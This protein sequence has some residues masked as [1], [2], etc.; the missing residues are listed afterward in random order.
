MDAADVCTRFNLPE[1]NINPKLAVRVEQI[2]SLGGFPDGC[3]KEV[4]VLL[5]KLASSARSL[6]AS[7][8]GAIARLVGEQA[9]V[10]NNQLEAAIKFLATQDAVDEE[11]LRAESGVGVNVSDE[12]LRAA[13]AAVVEAEKA[14]IA[15]MRYRTNTG[16]LVRKV[17][18]GPGADRLRWA[19][20]GSLKRAVDEAIAAHLGPKTEADLAETPVKKAPKDKGKGKPEPVNGK[21]VADN[22]VSEVVGAARKFPKPEENVGEP[23]FA[24]NDP[25]VL[26][27][28][29]HAT[30][31]KVITRFPPEPN[32]GGVGAVPPPPSPYGRVSLLTNP[33]GRGPR[34]LSAHRPRQSDANE[35][36]LREGHRRRDRVALRRHQPR[37]GGRALL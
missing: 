9:I 22:A 15:E 19:D 31:G 8:A 35:L 7:H 24:L 34:R 10:R 14:S 12:E 23:P 27:R 36:R 1:S 17:Q 18:T 13:A 29:L 3:S 6:P 11:R 5:F 21:A 4:G 25:A 37:G 28:H 2:A 32:G 33:A 26:R 30:G 16:V 20:G